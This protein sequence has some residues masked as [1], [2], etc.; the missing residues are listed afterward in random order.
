MLP[1]NKEGERLEFYLLELQGLQL[2]KEGDR[3]AY[4]KQRERERR[5]AERDVKQR[6]REKK[7]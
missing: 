7:H 4:V 2:M 6:E 3:E 5:E 1:T